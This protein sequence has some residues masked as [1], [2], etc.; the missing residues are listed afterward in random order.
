MN[1]T[2]IDLPGI[3]QSGDGEQ[4][5]RA[6][7]EK[8]YEN[9]RTLALC[10]MNAN[11]T[12]GNNTFNKYLDRFD[13]AGKRTLKILAKCDNIE[14]Q[15]KQEIASRLQSNDYPLHAVIC[16][17]EGQPYQAAAEH[18]AFQQ[19]EQ[20]GLDER[21]RELYCGISSLKVR[22]ENIFADSLKEV[23]PD[24]SDDWQRMKYER[25][26]EL[27]VVGKQA[28][29]P[30]ITLG[31]CKRELETY[32]RLKMKNRLTQFLNTFKKGIENTQ[33]RIKA[34]R[35]AEVTKQSQQCYV[36]TQEKL[37]E[38][39]FDAHM[40]QGA[41]AFEESLS[42][43]VDLLWKPE[44]VGFLT[45]AV[46]YVHRGVMIEEAVQF[47]RQ[48]VKMKGALKLSWSSFMH[49]GTSDDNMSLTEV[50][51]AKCMSDLDKELQFKTT[52]HD[53]DAKYTEQMQ[54]GRTRF[55]EDLATRMQA[56]LMPYINTQTSPAWGGDQFK[57]T[58]NQTYD[59]CSAAHAQ[60]E[61]NQSS[62]EQQK[63]RVHAALLSYCQVASDNLN[64]SI[65]QRLK[66]C[67]MEPYKKW[68]GDLTHDREVLDAAREDSDITRKREHLQREMEKLST[69]LLEL[70]KVS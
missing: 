70:N 64:D 28:P 39:M 29:P 47:D 38:N 32:L 22:L 4:E 37:E 6:M 40:F 33:A 65:L 68:V 69:C 58:F 55:K 23:L 60:L 17:P 36:Y 62:A 10:M 63:A 51:E 53:F 8:Y 25:E 46:N 15:K 56:Q 43:V 24:L 45:S 9:G 2:I 41:D 16:K 19:L 59:A 26:Q 3:V 5:T 48:P 54:A 57:T 13:L 20:H 67:I 35:G 50:F 21:T 31:K 18:S 27:S 52:K 1:I 30:E 49:D 66:S 61:E 11:S 12:E 14:Q 42:E 44:L 34:V 7:V